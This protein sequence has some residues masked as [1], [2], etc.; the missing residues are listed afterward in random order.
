MSDINSKDQINDEKMDDIEVKDLS[1]EEI[2]DEDIE[3]DDDNMI[4]NEDLEIFQKHNFE[5]EFTK[6]D[7]GMN[8]NQEGGLEG[9][10]SESAPLE[11]FHREYEGFIADGEIYS[12][13]MNEKGIAVLG[14]GEDTTY[15]Y[16]LNK[17]ELIRKEKINKDSVVNAEFSNDLKFVATASLDGSVNIFETEEF[18]LVNTFNGSFSDINVNN[19]IK[20]YFSF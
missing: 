16:D 15:F 10:E 5:F 13:S 2:E 12:I 9:G 4:D 17:K 8:V 1:V 14:D 18:K 11:D 20:I 3:F 19:L 6:G 7:E